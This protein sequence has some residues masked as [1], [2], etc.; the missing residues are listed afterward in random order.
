MRA[1]KRL[2]EQ[3]K[4]EH[5]HSDKEKGDHQIPVKCV[6]KRVGMADVIE[7][8]VHEKGDK[9]D[10]DGQNNGIFKKSKQNQSGKGSGRRREP[11]KIL[12]FSLVQLLAV[13]VRE[14]GQPQ[15]NK[16]EKENCQKQA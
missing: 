14:T 1:D 5:H 15:M 9:N 10:Q 12:F 16:N 3:Q 7:F 6:F 2:L 13:K 11:D 8:A 4:H